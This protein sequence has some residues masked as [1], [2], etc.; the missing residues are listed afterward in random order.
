MTIYV[1]AVL[2]GGE[3]DRIEVWV[4]G[5]R[6]GAEMIRQEDYPGCPVWSITRK[7]I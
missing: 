6:E 1:L 3:K 2:V 4:S 5:T 7:D